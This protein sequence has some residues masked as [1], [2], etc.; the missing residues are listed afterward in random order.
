MVHPKTDRTDHRDRLCMAVASSPALELPYPGIK[1]Q[2]QSH[3]RTTL[4]LRHLSA[5]AEAF[6]EGSPQKNNGR[7]PIMKH[8]VCVCVRI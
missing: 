8:S 3:L 7:R 1:V 2:Q 4:Q 5:G 6:F